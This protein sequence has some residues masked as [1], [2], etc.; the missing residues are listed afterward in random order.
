MVFFFFFFSA[1]LCRNPER[2]GIIKTGG[3][4]NEKFRTYE[5]RLESFRRWP[6]S[7]I[8][9]PERLAEAGFYYSGIHDNTLCFHCG[10]GLKNWEVDDDPWIEHARW[11]QKCGFINIQKGPKFVQEAIANKAAL[12][13]SK[14]CFFELQSLTFTYA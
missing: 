3:P 8:Q 4:V 11:F 9:S 7:E 5:H 10:G 12:L 1:S 6:K 2:L 14:V 13:S